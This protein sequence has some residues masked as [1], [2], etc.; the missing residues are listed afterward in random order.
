MFLTSLSI[1]FI[2]VG[3]TNVNKHNKI[4]SVMHNNVYK[5]QKHGFQTFFA[6]NETILEAL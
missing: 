1:Y 4:K 2:F 3:C 6:P 5:V